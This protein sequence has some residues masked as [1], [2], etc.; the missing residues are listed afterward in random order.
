M[1]CITHAQT[2][3]DPAIGQVIQD[4]KVFCQPDRVVKGH[5]ADVSIEPYAIGYCRHRTCNRCPTGQITVIDKVMFRKPDQ[6]SP[7]RLKP[8]NLFKY[9]SVQ[10][11]ILDT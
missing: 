1:W 3:F 5:E 2:D 8:A 9:F 11:G 10:D 4:G 7:Q 6:V